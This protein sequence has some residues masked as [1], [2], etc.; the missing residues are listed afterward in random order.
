MTKEETTNTSPENTSRVVN[1]KIHGLTVER[2]LS[3]DFT[4][5]LLNQLAT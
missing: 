2:F 4:D 3:S 5:G 1:L